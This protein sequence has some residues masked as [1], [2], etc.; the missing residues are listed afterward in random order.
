VG[1]IFSS[2]PTSAVFVPERRSYTSDLIFDIE[3]LSRIARLS[4]SSLPGAETET[5][6]NLVSFLR[7]ALNIRGSLAAALV[8][9]KTRQCLV[10]LGDPGFDLDVAATGN[11]VVVECTL[12]AL[13][14]SGADSGIDD[15]VMTL[16]SHY[17]LIRPLDRQSSMFIYL[18]LD[19]VEGNLGLA[20]LRLREL[21]NEHAQLR[22]LPLQ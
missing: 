18:V 2:E 5:A 8:E 1:R 7:G 10:A 11:C 20:R 4:T 16:G 3:E 13:H 19:R 17:H 6:L 15:I 14:D 9:L 21:T 22:A 12:K